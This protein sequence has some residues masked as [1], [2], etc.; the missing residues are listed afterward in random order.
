[1]DEKNLRHFCSPQYESK[2]IMH[3]LSHIDRVLSLAIKMCEKHADA[4]ME[5]II[6][7]AYFH[8]LVGNNADSIKEYLNSINFV[9]SKIE[10]ILQTTFES[11]VSSMPTSLEGKILHDAHLLEGG[12]TFIVTKCL[13]IG[14]ARGQS[15][16]ETIAYMEKKIIG[17]GA[18]F[19]EENQEEYKER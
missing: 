13:I 1:M 8:G 7:G 15:L 9:Q 16:A 6:F 18:V 17:K 10:K 3:N 14:T 5:T 19:L 11:Q 2:D 12:K 4:D